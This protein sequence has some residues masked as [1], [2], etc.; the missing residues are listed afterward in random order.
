M[1]GSQVMSHKAQAGQK[2]SVGRGSLAQLFLLH[3]CRNHYSWVRDVLSCVRRFRTFEPR[4]N[5]RAANEARGKTFKMAFSPFFA[6]DV[7]ATITSPACI[8]GSGIRPY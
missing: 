1:A 2:R 6:K 5:Y 3:L 7:S 4:A 8:G